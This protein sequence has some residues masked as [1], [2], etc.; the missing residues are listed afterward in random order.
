MPRHRP[1]SN[2]CSSGAIP[3]SRRALARAECHKSVGVARQDCGATGKI[4]NCQTGVYLAYA[5]A[6]GHTL[7]DERLDLPEEWARDGARRTEAGVPEGVV[8]RTKP[9]LA[10]ELIRTVG[11]KIRHGWVMFDEA[12][13]KDPEFL[14][15]AGG[16][17]KTAVF[18][19]GNQRDTSGAIRCGPL[20]GRTER[21]SRAGA[22]AGDRAQL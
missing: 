11:P 2:P 17:L 14:R 8:F 10:F 3:R 21:S 9:E 6:A 4:D 12:Y 1:G 22:V 16:R 18:S 15:V 5:S 19:R 7:L 20:C 13:G